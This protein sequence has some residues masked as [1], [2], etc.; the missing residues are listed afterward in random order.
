M[1]QEQS[2]QP[3]GGWPEKRKSTS[4]PGS[5]AKRKKSIA[6]VPRAFEIKDDD[7]FILEKASRQI[8]G[9]H[10]SINDV[11]YKSLDL[12]KS[13]AEKADEVEQNRIE[14]SDFKY[15][16][17]FVPA[18]ERELSEEVIAQLKGICQDY[19]WPNAKRNG[20]T[21]HETLFDIP[22]AVLQH[23][24]GLHLMWE[25]PPLDE[26]LSWT[27]S[28]LFVIVHALGR[29]ENGQRVP[30]ISC[31]RASGLTTTDGQS[32][33]FYS[34]NDLHEAY[35]V[36]NR[37]WKVGPVD[38]SHGD[39]SFKL[40]PRKF[41]HEWLSHGE[42]R[43]SEHE[44]KHVELG[45]MILQG[46]F[47][48][49]PELD[50]PGL[51]ERTGLYEHLTAFRLGMF[52]CTKDSEITTK[53]MAVC[54]NIA[55]LFRKPGQEKAPLSVLLDTLSLRKRMARND[56]FRSWI[57]KNYTVEEVR[58]EWFPDIHIIPDNLPEVK[59]SVELLRE[60][61][62]ALDLEPTPQIFLIHDNGGKGKNFGEYKVADL[63]TTC[64]MCVEDRDEK[65]NHRT[66]VLRNCFQKDTDSLK[67][68]NKAT[69]QL[70]AD[71]GAAYSKGLTQLLLSQTNN[72]KLNK[73]EKAANLRRLASEQVDESDIEAPEDQNEEDEGEG[74]KE[75]S[76]QTRDI[77]NDHQTQE[78]ESSTETFDPQSAGPSKR[79]ATEEPSYKSK[80]N[81]A[82]AI[83][84]KTKRQAS[85]STTKEVFI[86]EIRK[87]CNGMYKR[88]VA[89]S[90]L[91]AADREFKANIL[92]G[93]VLS[94]STPVAAAHQP[95]TIEDSDA[96]NSTTIFDIIGT[97]DRK[98]DSSQA[99]V[100]A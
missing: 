9:T 36:L 3:Q 10:Y 31:G 45:E 83:R 51:C 93:L 89:R 79:P 44:M 97:A 67:R 88:W 22:Y 37:A 5:V 76:L 98:P 30:I 6:R 47:H 18:D 16:K 20:R 59:Q 28:W 32:A 77:V 7:K 57:V 39:V 12:L 68:R 4:K 85:F 53:D 70:W 95:L 41:A 34:A 75:N 27:D 94:V 21:M 29:Y 24:L 72:W 86:E 73:K 2:E 55:K 80:T 50:M 60:A 81:Y 26:L 92:P 48:L 38:S 65:Q 90:R 69:L 8:E 82:S 61:F 64:Q 84:D 11:P 62:A 58:E 99:F 46:L 49:Y 63:R 23:M 35:Q 52:Y 15:K 78:G 100:S 14:K 25:D 19:Y 33:S 54:E 74:E 71:S 87:H 13:Y 56:D 91:R 43:D 66:K 1:S 17:V 40:D 42:V 96:S